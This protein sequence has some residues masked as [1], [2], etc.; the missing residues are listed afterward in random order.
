M[1]WVNKCKLLAIKTIKYNGQPCIEIDDL[2]QALHLTFNTAQHYIINEEVL[3]E[4]EFFANSLW[5]L[6]LEEEFTSALTKYNNLSTPDPN[7]L[8]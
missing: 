3:N 4:L 6:F 8:A 5:N 7:K 1:N 2:W